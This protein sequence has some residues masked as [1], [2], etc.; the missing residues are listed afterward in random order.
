MHGALL[1]GFDFFSSSFTPFFG[2]YLRVKYSYFRKVAL[3]MLLAH[4]T[5]HSHRSFQSNQRTHTSN[6]LMDLADGAVQS[7]AIT[8]RTG[9]WSRD[10][11]WQNI[12]LP[13]SHASTVRG[14]SLKIL[15]EN[16]TW[17]KITT[18]ICLRNPSVKWHWSAALKD[19]WITNVQIS[20]CKVRVTPKIKNKYHPVCL[21]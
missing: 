9:P 6:T 21:S 15:T 11:F 4:W 2:T 3:L 13:L 16:S 18:W 17:R 10:M 8:L 12:W 5:I 7:V 19:E 20:S 1:H 14:A